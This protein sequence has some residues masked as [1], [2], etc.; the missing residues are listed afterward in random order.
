[1]LSFELNLTN[2]KKGTTYAKI[3]YKTIFSMATYYTDPRASLFQYGAYSPEKAGTKLTPFVLS[4]ESAYS[5]KL[6]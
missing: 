5:N 2:T 4:T 6:L 3:F 1:M